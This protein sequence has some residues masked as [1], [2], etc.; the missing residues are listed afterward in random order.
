MSD[1]ATKFLNDHLKLW[2]DSVVL[3][4]LNEAQSI[5][6]WLR[7]LGEH[8]AEETKNRMRARMLL[9]AEAAR[10]LYEAGPE[11]EDEAGI[12]ENRPDLRPRPE[13]EYQG[14]GQAPGNSYE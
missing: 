12:Y 9:L 11:A 1:G 5:Q 6:A 7:V 13:P 10:K 3:A 2:M 4:P 8:G 14:D